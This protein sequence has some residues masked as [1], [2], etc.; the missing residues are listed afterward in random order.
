MIDMMNFIFDNN[1][2]RARQS[3]YLRVVMKGIDTS[4]SYT[5]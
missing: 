5:I 3:E 2:T 1:T 4:T